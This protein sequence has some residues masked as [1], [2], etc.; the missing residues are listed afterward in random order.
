MTYRTGDLLARV[1][2]DV[3]VLEN[4]YVRLVAPVLVAGLTALGVGAFLGSFS[5]GLALVVVGSFGAVGGLL[6]LWMG[7]L[8]RAPAREV[9]LARARLSALLVDSILGLAD[10][11]SFGRAADF[12]DRLARAD[13]AYGRAQGR[14]ARLSALHTS[15]GTLLAN[16]ALWG[17]LLLGIPLVAAGRVEGVMLGALGLVALT[18]FEA[19]TPLPQAAQTWESVRTA[20]GRLLELADSPLPVAD[21]PPPFPAPPEDWT[22]ELEGLT[23]TYPGADRP[24]LEE[25][26]LRVPAG[27]RVAIVGPSGAGKSTL[28][29]LLLRFWEYDRGEIRLG[30]VPLKALPAE[31]VRAFFAVVPQHAEAL[32]A[33]LRENLLLANPG[34]SEEELAAVVRAARLEETVAQ[35][36]QGYDTYL[37]ERGER[38]SAG[39]RQRLAIA[40]ALLR[41]APIL[42]VDEPTAHLDPATEREVVASLLRRARGRTVLWITHRLVG[43]E[44]MDEIVVLDRGRIVERGTHEALLAQGGLYRRLW[45]LQR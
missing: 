25:V 11:L 41:R 28:A 16:L 12:A 33:T 7:R 34:A 38:L 4:L 19:A 5:P 44:G 24:A 14:L 3:E 31:T 2:G 10:L 42:L 20:A 6:P 8:G 18:A 40:R 26:T 37:G 35:L 17:V 36:S 1:V 32:S 22:L 39:Q 13:A 21:P 27:K 23:F 9:V 15:L 45:E 43:M 29:H 30:G